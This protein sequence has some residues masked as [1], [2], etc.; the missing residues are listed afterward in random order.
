MPVSRRSFFKVA[1]A[2]G[3]GALALPLI[4][5]RGAEAAFGT[6][7]R[8]KA[9]AP[10]AIRLDS[11]ENPNG[12]GT[13]ALDA[14]R[15]AFGGAN[16]YTDGASVPLIDAIAKARGVA[17]ENV[18]LGCGSTE[19]LHLATRAFTSPTKPLVTASPTFEEPATVA[20][21]IGTPVRRV[22]VTNTLKLD[23][24]AMAAASRDAG[25][26]YLCNPNNP[27]ATVHG[28]AAVKDFVR[29]VL[30]ASPSTT[31][32]IDEAYHEFVEDPSYATALPIA[33]ENP[34]VFVARTFSKIYGL[35]GMRTGY[36][37][38]RKETVDAMAR[39]KLP[40]NINMLAI[41]GVLA[42]LNDKVH[43]ERERQL[44]RDARAYTHQ[45]FEKAGYKV[46][47]S[48]ANFFMVDIRRDSK[49]FQAVCEKRGVLV[50]RPF[51]PLTNY[52][53]ISI[54]T[55]DEMRRATEVFKQVL[56]PA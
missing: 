35:A 42:T 6:F 47:P 28:A 9:I 30:R 56:A 29:D 50:G 43:I 33:M 12:P 8:H 26:V 10:G 4:S 38:G 14:I 24:A 16:R 55:I 51:P 54:G 34:R 39:F 31:I 3:V 53:R 13:V 5:A 52:A 15:A 21:A 23:L 18:I 45:W 48:E 36:A 22:P 7:G 11:N 20:D 17:R 49:Q 41:H 2:G 37:M 44:N 27:T 25:L 19:I 46:I 1:G 40:A 32:L